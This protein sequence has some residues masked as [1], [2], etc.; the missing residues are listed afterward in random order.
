MKEETKLYN[1]GIREIKQYL[2]N[3]YP[4]LLIDGVTELFPGVR[5]KGYKNVTANE[6]FFQGHFPNDPLMPGMIQVEALFQ[7]LSL[8]VLAIE[9]NRG[10]SVRGTFA[11]KIKL[12]NRVF[13]G[14]RLNI[15]AQLTD[16]DGNSGKGIGKGVVDG[17]EVC[18]AEFGFVMTE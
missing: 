15:E 6:A 8:T 7:M 18:S 10:K 1:M 14:S 9:G 4:F 5:A 12:K 11:D 2:T 13:P 17:K 3:R 16:W